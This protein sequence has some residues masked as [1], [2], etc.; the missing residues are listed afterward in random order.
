[1]IAYVYYVALMFDYIV[2][3]GNACKAA[4]MQ[5]LSIEHF[6]RSA[7]LEFG[8]ARQQVADNCDKRPLYVVATMGRRSEKI[9]GGGLKGSGGETSIRVLLEAN[10]R[11]SF[12]RFL[13]NYKAE[14]ALKQQLHSTN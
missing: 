5:D 7:G 12:Y 10:P 6:G 14:Y 1:M 3:L 8:F 2:G 9:V 13:N 4:E 11:R